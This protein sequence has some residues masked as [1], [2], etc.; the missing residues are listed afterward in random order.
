MKLDARYNLYTR[1]IIM[2][3]A[4]I[5]KQLLDEREMID[6]AIDSLERIAL[7]RGK[8]R[9]RPPAWMTVLEQETG[10]PKRRGRPPKPGTGKK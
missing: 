1:V 4:A 7:H 2:D 6:R 8:R 9:G 10:S 3:L 5:V